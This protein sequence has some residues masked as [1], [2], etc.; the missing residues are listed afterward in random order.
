MEGDP[1]ALKLMIKYCIQDIILLEKIYYKLRGYMKTHPNVATNKYSSEGLHGVQCPK[2]GSYRNHKTMVRRA[3]SGK[4]HQQYKCLAEDCNSYFQLRK[5]D[6][7]NI[8]TKI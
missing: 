6:P 5:A 8:I 4:V 7:K 1:K 3:A 2:C